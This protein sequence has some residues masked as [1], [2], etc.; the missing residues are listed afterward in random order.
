[1]TIK[2]KK[3]IFFSLLTVIM[4]SGFGCKSCPFQK[5]ENKP[6]TLNWWGV[7]ETNDDVTDLINGFKLSHPNVNI[8]YRK[9][10]Y[11]DYENELLEALAED[12]GPDIFSL[13]N[14]WINKYKTK[15]LAQPATVTLTFQEIKGALKKEPILTQKKINTLSLNQIKNQFVETVYQDV[16]LDNQIYG[17]PLSLDTLALYY[18]SDLLN[19]FGVAT[20]PK[21]W[22]E[23][24]NAVQKLTLFNEDEE[25]IQAGATLGTAENVPRSFDILSLLMMQNGT[26]MTS[27]DNRQATFNQLQPTNANSQYNPGLVA[28][29][30]YT[31]YANPAKVIYTW[32]N[33]MPNAYEQFCSNKVAFFFGYSYHY[34]QIKNCAPQLNLGITQF[35]Q[36][37][38]TASPLNYANYWVLSV[39]KKSLLS[40]AAWGFINF[41]VQKENNKIYLNKTKRPTALRA[42][43]EE[44]LADEENPQLQVFASQVLTARSWYH[45]KD[46]LAAENYFSQMIDNV[47]TGALTPQESINLAV[48]QI[49]STF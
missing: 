20:P 19:N 5:V 33:Q 38:Q 29:T 15:L 23:F 7:W 32:N 46:P 11:E 44:Q 4:V 21:T 43:V 18:N 16:V 25:I 13:P 17:L 3:I 31:D 1:M 2:L 8:N 49:N 40:D 48:S 22:D 41:A 34:S 36:I 28:L 37:D 9:F 30:Y 10:R 47:L 39:S 14:T 6:I 24:N 42:L 35:P 27:S 26:A 45:G 12:R